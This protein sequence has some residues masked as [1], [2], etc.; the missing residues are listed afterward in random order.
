V[1]IITLVRGI[2][3]TNPQQWQQE[4]GKKEEEEKNLDDFLSSQ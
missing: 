3:M 1:S 2:K 4:A